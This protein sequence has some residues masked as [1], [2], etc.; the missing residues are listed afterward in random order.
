MPIS[1]DTRRV[2][3]GRLSVAVAVTFV[4]IGALRFATDTL[5]EFNPDYWRPLIGTPFRYLVRAPSDGTVPG[6][7]NAQFFKILSIPAGLCLVWLGVRFGSGTLAHKAERFRDLAVRGTW[8]LSFLAGFSLIEL[9]KT[10]HFLGM[11]AVLVAGERAWLNHV[12]HV[13][14]A[15]LAWGLTDLLAFEP[16][17][18]AEIAL[19]REL[20]ALEPPA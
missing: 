18:Y 17:T 20:D 8:A 10:Y 13:A 14:S 11:N 19:E 7:L 12:V 1:N 4:I 6:F 16:L 9:E 15:V 2:W 3:A 5:H